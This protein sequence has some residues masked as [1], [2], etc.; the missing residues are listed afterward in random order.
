MDSAGQTSSRS[1]QYKP[2]DHQHTSPTAPVMHPEW[3]AFPENLAHTPMS[4]DTRKN[5]SE[6]G[7]GPGGYLRGISEARQGKGPVIPR[8]F[9]QGPD[10]KRSSSSIIQKFGS[11][12]KV[13]KDLR[14]KP[15]LQALTTFYQNHFPKGFFNGTTS[16]KEILDALD[17]EDPD[18][19]TPIAIDSPWITQFL[20][21]QDEA[22]RRPPDTVEWLPGRSRSVFKKHTGT[23]R[24]E[25]REDSGY[26]APKRVR[27][28]HIE[29]SVEQ[30]VHVDENDLDQSQVESRTD[31]LSEN[32]DVTATPPFVRDQEEGLLSRQVDHAQRVGSV[33]SETSLHEAQSTPL[34]EVPSESSVEATPWRDRDIRLPPLFA[35]TDREMDGYNLSLIIKAC[36][37][38]EDLQFVVPEDLKRYLHMVI[39]LQ[40]ED[41]ISGVV[42]TTPD[43]DKRH[44]YTFRYMLLGH[45]EL[46]RGRDENCGISGHSIVP[47]D[48]YS[49]D[50]KTYLR[51]FFD[52]TIPMRRQE[53]DLGDKIKALKP[54]AVLD[55][56]L[57]TSRDFIT[58][59][60]FNLGDLASMIR[61]L[62][63][64]RH[65]S[66]HMFQQADFE[67]IAEQYGLRSE[68]PSVKPELRSVMTDTLNMLFTQTCQPH[69]ERVLTYQYCAWSFKLT[70]VICQEYE[71][72]HSFEIYEDTP[73][74]ERAWIINAAFVQLH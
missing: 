2:V 17:L 62:L 57:L 33:A 24:R 27:Q 25:I 50:C 9:L 46:S 16:L 29:T 11:K 8:A 26:R 44:V 6:P 70:R 39:R 68:L 31:M 7:R 67:H 10:R 47:F 74:D 48:D 38:A 36:R 14:K 30:D 72:R 18:H 51:S 64:S 12:S 55:R 52:S 37:H 43:F 63:N 69:S 56:E 4:Y 32:I 28:S 13:L 49:E 15:M 34:T 3:L 66:P 19:G 40:D 21:W 41:R 61:I 23:K 60:P 1:G 71:L 5:D 53:I 65:P 20:R 73:F 35:A 54:T 58:S 42:T 45:L 22:Y 59:R